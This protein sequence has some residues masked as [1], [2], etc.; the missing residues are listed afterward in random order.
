MCIY[1]YFV[2]IMKKYIWKYISWCIHKIFLKINK[3][4]FQ[5]FSWEE[6]LLGSVWENLKFSLSILWIV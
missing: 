4:V 5:S 3:E 1:D 6:Q 2:Q